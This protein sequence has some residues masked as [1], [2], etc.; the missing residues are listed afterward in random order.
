LADIIVD[1]DV[2][3]ENVRRLSGVASVEGPSDAHIK[4]AVHGFVGQFDFWY[5]RV[6]R[7]A[8]GSYRDLIIKRIN[9]FIR[10]IEFDGFS[11]TDT[12]SK[13]VED[14]NAR[15][16]VTAG[17]WALEA[18]A[19]HISP[20]AQKSTAAGIDV[21]RVERASGDYHLYVLKS[22]LVTRNSDILNALKRNA[23]QAE[24]LLRQGNSQTNVHA[25]YAIVA[26]KTESSFEDGI[27]RLSSAEFWAHMTELPERDAVELVLAVAAEAGRLVRRDASEHIDAMKLLVRDYIAMRDNSEAVDW[28]FIAF[29]NMQSATLWKAADLERH[30]RALALLLE[31]GY[32][33]DK[34]RVTVPRE[35]TRARS[36]GDRLPPK[37]R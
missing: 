21:Q 37:K 12:A 11:A 35:R 30:K 29:R 26:G 28:E 6:M 33:P 10:R 8:V 16:F 3:V 24:K 18:L 27:S 14:Y 31:T 9:P 20:S 15:N 2:I 34:K 13:L 19:I 36:T 23:R 32:V 5:T 1:A 25:H 4:A 17:G 7:A 22:G